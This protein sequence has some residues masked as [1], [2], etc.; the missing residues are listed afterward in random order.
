M[1]YVYS[2]TVMIDGILFRIECV[3]RDWRVL[4]GGVPPAPTVFEARATLCPGQGDNP[5]LCDRAALGGRASEAVG[6]LVK[7]LTTEVRRAKSVE[8]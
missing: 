8:L 7:L 1:K 5:N 4:G 2:K 6:N 3:E